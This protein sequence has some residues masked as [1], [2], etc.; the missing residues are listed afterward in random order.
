MSKEIVPG[1]WRDEAHMVDYRLERL[2]DILVERATWSDS[3]PRREIRETVVADSGYIWFRFWMLRDE[4][5]VEKYFRDDGSAIGTYALVCL[6]FSGSEYGLRTTELTLAVWIDE[7]GRVMVLRE[8]QFE[9]DVTN[10]LISSEQAIIAEE[11]IRKMTME[12]SQKLYPP[13]IVRNFELNLEQ[14]S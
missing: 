2:R 11:R 13:A 8:S 9:S 6:P 12:I 7:D 5:V 4:T 10:G 14:L 3:A 1:L